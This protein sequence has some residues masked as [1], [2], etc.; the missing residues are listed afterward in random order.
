VLG[1]DEADDN[2]WYVFG[3]IAESYGLK[4]EAASMYRR[5]ERP[6]NERLIPSSSYPL[7]QKRLRVIAAAK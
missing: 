3:R 6:R 1:E 7:A 4:D 2:D 5:L